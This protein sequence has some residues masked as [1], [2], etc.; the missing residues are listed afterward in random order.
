MPSTLMTDLDRLRVFLRVVERGSFTA[1]A[2]QLGMPVT[3]ASRRVRALEE[4]LGVRLL[5]RTTRSV[6]LT[7]EGEAL[8]P[9]AQAMLDAEAAARASLAPG[10]VRASGTLRVTAPAAFG[11]KVVMPLMPGFLADHP[12]LRVELHLTD[13]IVDIAALG[14][15]AAVRIGRLRSSS[16]IARRLVANPRLLCA[17]P[18]YLARAG[19][20]ASVD[21]L[22]GHECIVLGEASVWAFEAAGR[23]REVR[24]AGR[25][26]SSTIEAVRE[27]CVGGLGLALLSAWDVADEL[28][29][30]GL[31]ALELDALPPQELAIWAVYPSARFVPVKVWAFI[32]ALEGVL[33]SE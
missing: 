14:I 6:S 11:R 30:G 16:L 24:V 17:A 18:A 1:A 32:A 33:K 31:V 7:P 23:L 5:H 27:A 19:T 12:G 28:R 4:D 10:T 8:L 13:D 22:P 3:S 29:S 9:H 20:P 21:E 15:D 2:A 25:F 26:A